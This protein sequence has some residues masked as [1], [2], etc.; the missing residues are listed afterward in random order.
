M[1]I[2][3][4]N[5]TIPIATILGASWVFI[6]KG[7]YGFIILVAGLVLFLLNWIFEYQ[8]EMERIRQNY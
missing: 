5:I 3:I 6:E 2:N 8:L 4:S 1:D 7:N